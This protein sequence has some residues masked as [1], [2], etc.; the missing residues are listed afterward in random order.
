MQPIKPRDRA[1]TEVLQHAP[2][3]QLPEE[4][5]RNFPGLMRTRRE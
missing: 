5:L 4:V 2:R 3:L 1:L